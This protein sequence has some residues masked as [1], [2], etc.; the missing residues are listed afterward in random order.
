MPILLPHPIQALSEQAFHELDYGV[1]ALAFEV[2]NEY[3]RFYNEAI[4][5]E[6]LKQKCLDKG[7]EVE[8]ELKIELAYE[9]YRKSLFID[10]LIQSSVYELKT[11]K[12]IQEA[13]RIQTLNYLFSINTQHGKIINFQPASVEHEFIS[14]TLN[15]TLRKQIRIQDNNWREHSGVAEKLRGFLVDLLN[16][17]GAFLSTQ[18]Y[19]EALIHLLGGKEHIIRPVEVKHN[20]RILGSQKLNVLSESEFFMITANRKNPLRHGTHL[21]K[22]LLH[23][24]FEHLYW[25]NLNHSHLQ[26]TTLEK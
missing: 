6:V 12:T 8:C 21:R 13:Q 7:L 1:M 15:E 14:T 19:E 2:H 3:G 11:I 16:D 24:P 20:D 9:D 17:W 23:S 4:Y 10:L 22:L 26:L 18:I 25:I 5:Q